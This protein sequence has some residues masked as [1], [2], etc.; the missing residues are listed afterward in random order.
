M[1]VTLQNIL[2]YA[3]ESVLFILLGRKNRINL[4]SV[5][6]LPKMRTFSLSTSLNFFLLATSFQ[7]HS[8]CDESA[9]PDGS[10]SSLVSLLAYFPLGNI[11]LSS[12]GK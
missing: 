10:L 6:R 1:C 2:V 12:A 9:L 4:G 11:S 5:P 7:I 8:S 3:K